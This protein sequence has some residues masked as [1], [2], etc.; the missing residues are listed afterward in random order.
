[1]KQHSKEFSFNKPSS[2]IDSIPKQM[3][4]HRLYTRISNTPTPLSSFVRVSS[5]SLISVPK[6]LNDYYT[7]QLLTCYHHS[8]KSSL[9][10]QSR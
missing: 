5:L 4:N 1:M 10:R 7:L 2:I 9:L 3:I 6:Y 8:P